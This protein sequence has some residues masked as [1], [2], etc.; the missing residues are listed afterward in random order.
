MVFWL[1]LFE[2]VRCCRLVKGEERY[3]FVKSNYCRACI[4]FIENSGDYE[5]ILNTECVLMR[6]NQIES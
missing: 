2:C 6:F 3:L 5:T 1:M 4:N